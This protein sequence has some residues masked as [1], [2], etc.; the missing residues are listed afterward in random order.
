MIKPGQICGS[1]TKKKKSGATSTLSRFFFLLSKRNEITGSETTAP[2]SRL[3]LSV[4]E[5]LF[6]NQRGMHSLPSVV[7]GVP[8]VRNSNY[9]LLMTFLIR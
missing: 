6:S 4:G 9:S 1:T 5:H 2:V 7:G 8:G 3:A